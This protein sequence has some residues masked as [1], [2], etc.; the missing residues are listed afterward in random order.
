LDHSRLAAR[1]LGPTNQRVPVLAEAQLGDESPR[2]GLRRTTGVHHAR[3]QPRLPAAFVL[4]P[5]LGSLGDWRHRR[6]PSSRVTG[7]D[8]LAAAGSPGLAL[9]RPYRIHPSPCTTL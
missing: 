7:R 1:Y 2:V 9:P 8:R 5:R 3:R 4:A 6:P